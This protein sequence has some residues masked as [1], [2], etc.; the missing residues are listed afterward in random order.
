MSSLD[1]LN[2]WTYAGNWQTSSTVGCRNAHDSGGVAVAVADNKTRKVYGRINGRS[3]DFAMP[4]VAPVLG[5]DDQG[6]VH[7]ITLLFEIQTGQWWC[8]LWMNAN[9]DD[10][11]ELVRS[12]GTP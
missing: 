7:R 1:P 10:R 9:Q 4:S 3:F 8:Y 11:P 2:G 5:G 12:I 6:A